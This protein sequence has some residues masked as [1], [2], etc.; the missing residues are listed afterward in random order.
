[1]SDKYHQI[2]LHYKNSFQQFGFNS[3]GLNWKNLK[4]NNIRFEIAS[5]Y[6]D[7]NISSILDFGCGTSLFYDYLKKKKIKIIYTGLD[8]DKSVIEYCKKRNKEI[9]YYNFD[10]L[11]NNNFKKNFDCVFANGMFT[12]KL[13]LSEKYMY[14][15]TFK[16]LIKMFKITKKKLIFNVL[17]NVVDWKNPKNFYVSLDKITNFLKKNLSKKFIIRHDYNNFECFII[18]KKK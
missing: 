17:N 9:N 10:I 7:K 2:I 6:L 18:V 13:N 14:E 1:M 4:L 3:K 12:Q 8:T 15:Y 5:E 16:M 11:K